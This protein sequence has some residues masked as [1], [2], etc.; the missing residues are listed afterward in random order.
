MLSST[1]SA[2]NT[3]SPLPQLPSIISPNPYCQLV[4]TSNGPRYIPVDAAAYGTAP[5]VAPS[6]ASSVSTTNTF[7]SNNNQTMVGLTIY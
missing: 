5:S 3:G 4:Q 2:S 1:Q 7:D 6:V